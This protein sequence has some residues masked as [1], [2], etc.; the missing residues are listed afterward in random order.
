MVPSSVD[1]LKA[2]GGRFLYLNVLDIPILDYHRKKSTN[3]EE[4]SFLK[5]GRIFFFEIV[6]LWSLIVHLLL[7][8]KLKRS[9][10]AEA[11]DNLIKLM[12]NQTGCSKSN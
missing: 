9:R 11:K 6:G 4:T 1:S 7:Y 8:Q 2:T 12:I 10:T 5:I 3:L